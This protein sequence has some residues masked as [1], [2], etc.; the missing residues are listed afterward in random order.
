[1]SRHLSARFRAWHGRWLEGH[2]S[3]R[4]EQLSDDW[5]L[6]RVDGLKP[7]RTSVQRNNDTTRPPYAP[8]SR[9]RV[10]WLAA[11]PAAAASTASSASSTSSGG[12]GGGGGS[13]DK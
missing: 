4:Q 1:M 13:G 9:Y 6:G 11:E 3:Q 10:D 7:S 2:V 12:G 5:F 8:Y